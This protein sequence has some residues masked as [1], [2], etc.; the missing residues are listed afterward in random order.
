MQCQIFNKLIKYW[1]KL[2]LPFCEVTQPRRSAWLRTRLAS[3]ESCFFD[4]FSRS[5]LTGDAI[6]GLRIPSPLNAPTGELPRGTEN[7]KTIIRITYFSFWTDMCLQTSINYYK[8]K[9]NKIKINVFKILFS[10]ERQL[11]DVF[12]IILLSWII[13]N[14]KIVNLYVPWDILYIHTLR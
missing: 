14:Q 4:F 5:F 2:Q 9:M 1:I 12:V 6:K 7:K 11:L 3:S 10:W 13:T 8:I